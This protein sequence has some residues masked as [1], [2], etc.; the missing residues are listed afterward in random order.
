[1]SQ[2]EK[3]IARLGFKVCGMSLNVIEIEI[4]FV[5]FAKTIYRLFFF[6]FVVIVIII[7]GNNHVD[8]KIERP[9]AI[10]R[11]VKKEN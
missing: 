2:K 4:V 5:I 8:K 6:V 3:K 10:T 9:C 11:Q 1:M 7:K